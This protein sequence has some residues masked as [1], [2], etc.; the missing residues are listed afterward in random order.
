[1]SS[2][3]EK[4]LREVAAALRAEHRLLRAMMAWMADRLTDGTGPEAIREQ[5]R[6]LFAAL[7]DHARYE[8]SAL[9]DPLRR[10]S[11]AL[12]QWVEQMEIVHEEV[13]EVFQAAMADADPREALWT[14]LQLSEEH[15]ETEE[16]KVFPQAEI[17]EA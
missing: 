7:D 17:E 16:Q 10:R 3:E 14:L 4:P 15:F 11:P 9:F 8:E 13:R 1:M 5:A 2:L 6:A 12:R